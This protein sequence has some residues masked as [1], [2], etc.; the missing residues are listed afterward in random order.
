MKDDGSFLST[1][2]YDANPPCDGGHCLNGGV[3]VQE[4]VVV[5]EGTGTS[6]IDEYCDCSQSF[7]GDF[8]AGT[9]CQYKSTSV[10]LVQNPP[11]EASES[12]FCVHHGDCNSD[13]SCSCPH[14]WTGQHCEFK[15]LDGDQVVAGKTD[16]YMDEEMKLTEVDKCVDSIC[17]NGGSC[18]ETQRL[19]PN[20]GVTIESHC[21]CSTAFDEKYIYAG[22]SCEFPH[23]QVCWVPEEGDDSSAPV[24]CTNHG[25]CRDT[26]QLGCDCPLGFSGPACEYE[27]HD[28]NNKKGVNDI[29]EVCGDGICHNGG[30]CVTSTIYNEVTGA[31]KSSYSCDC[32]SAYDDETAYLGESCEY[33]A[34][35]MCTPAKPGEPLSSARFCVNHGACNQ[36]PSKDCECGDGFEGKFCELKVD[37]DVFDND[38]SDDEGIE[39]FELCRN[40]DGFVFPCFNVSQKI[41]AHLFVVFP[42][43]S[44]K[45]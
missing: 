1:T 35:D 28:V 45:A 9:Y 15:T 31:S 22:T 17:Y 14:G 5:R 11:Q 43:T 16:F 8:Y 23:T 37:F 42:L 19:Q 10:C 40:G 26:P 41:P 4:Q 7:D 25:S 34:T 33:P 13:G 18:I 36:D 24:F 44:L 3:C 27:L 12:A 20:G 32:S 39:E 2:N 29:V 38:G 30:K 21:D 6:M